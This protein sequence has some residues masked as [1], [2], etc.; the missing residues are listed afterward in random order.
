MIPYRNQVE[1]P[2]EPPTWFDYF[3]DYLRAF[4][5]TSSRAIE[6]EIERFKETGYCHLIGADKGMKAFVYAFRMENENA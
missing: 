6:K 3:S 5:R 2:N 4:S 1:P